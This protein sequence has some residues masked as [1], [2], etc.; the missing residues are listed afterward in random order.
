MQEMGIERLAVWPPEFHIPFEGGW[1]VSIGIEE[2]EKA[3]VH[4]VPA[5]IMGPSG[6]IQRHS[7]KIFP[8]ETLRPVLQK[9]ARLDNMSGIEHTAVCPFEDFAVWTDMFAD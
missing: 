6:Y 8:S 5:E 7:G 1:T 2:I 4:I 9:P 3:T